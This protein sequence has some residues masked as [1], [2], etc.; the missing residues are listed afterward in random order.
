MEQMPEEP[1]LV[2]LPVSAGLALL[3]AS[4]VEAVQG[5]VAVGRAQL[6]FK[7]THIF[8]NDNPHTF[9]LGRYV[10][11]ISPRPVSLAMQKGHPLGGDRDE[12]SA[13]HQTCS[14]P[15]HLKQIEAITSAF[16]LEELAWLQAPG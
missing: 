10:H 2:G 7:P 11:R 14:E 8:A 16:L 3:W 5:V 15:R 6:A 4:G 12:L 9:F 1:L 13:I